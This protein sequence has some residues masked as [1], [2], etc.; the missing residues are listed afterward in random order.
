MNTILVNTVLGKVENLE[1]LLP[2]EFAVVE[3][4]QKSGVL[5]HLF[6]KEAGTGAVLV[7]NETDEAKVRELIT[8]LP[9]HTHFEKTEIIV[10]DKKF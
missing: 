7:F 9:L 10:L 8:Q 2:H 6:L 5:A 3:G 4:W 1:E